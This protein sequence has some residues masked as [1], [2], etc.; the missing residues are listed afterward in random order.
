MP[1]LKT[2]I[3]LIIFNRPSTTEKVFEAIRQA[4]PPQLLVI[5]DGPRANRPDELEKCTAARAIIKKVDWEC[6]V[7]T[8]YSDVNL[9]CKK[10]VSSGLDWVFQNVEEAIILEDD[11]LPN[12]TFFLYCEELLKRYRD[13]ERVM[14]ICGSNPIFQSSEPELNQKISEY[15]YYFSRYCYCW[16]WATWKRAWQHYDV[17]MKFLPT[18][19]DKGLIKNV[20]GNEKDVEPWKNTLLEI[21]NGQID[22]WDHQWTFTCWLQ[23]G[24]SIVSNINLISNIGHGAEAT[25]TTNPDSKYA[26]IPTQVMKFPLSH[27][28][29]IIRD[30]DADDYAQKKLFSPDLSARI[31]IAISKWIN[32]KFWVK[33][34]T[35]LASNY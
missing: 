34:Y 30:V 24:L 7:L 25:H 29:Y 6:E 19:L 8:N 12:P 16:G 17:Q 27:P 35:K 15:S 2:A 13:D 32:K 23:S 9:G 33:M 22:T 4:K 1:Q 26:N 11:C 28:P 31:K 5:A 18:A 21:Y 10:R 14:A 20:L 3:A